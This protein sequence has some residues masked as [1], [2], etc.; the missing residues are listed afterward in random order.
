M[1]MTDNPHCVG[2]DCKN[3]SFQL[4][5][6]VQQPESCECES[7]AAAALCHSLAEAHTHAAS[8]P[9]ETRLLAGAAPGG[10]HFSLFL[11]CKVCRSGKTT[12][13]Q[14]LQGLRDVAD[15]QTLSVYSTTT[16][17]TTTGRIFHYLQFHKHV[18]L[19]GGQQGMRWLDM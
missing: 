1:T 14:T 4:H 18:V 19:S 7:R 11:T 3:T 13:S 16:T 2:A 15:A 5:G 6:T 12:K 8:E 10:E 17:K 9:V